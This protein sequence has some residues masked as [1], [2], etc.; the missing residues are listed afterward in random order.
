MTVDRQN[1][2]TIVNYINF[3]LQGIMDW[4]TLCLISVIQSYN[5]KDRFKLAVLI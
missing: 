4:L 1:K 2:T 5:H 3:S